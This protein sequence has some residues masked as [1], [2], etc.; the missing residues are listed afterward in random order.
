MGVPV[1]VTFLGKATIADQA[2]EGSRV[3]MTSQVLEKQD[4]LMKCLHA[5]FAT[6][7]RIVSSSFR[8]VN[9]NPSVVLLEQLALL[10]QQNAV[11]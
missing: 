9:P 7:Q 4:H 10:L 1:P 11:L 2:E 5:H 3:E 6:E 8:I